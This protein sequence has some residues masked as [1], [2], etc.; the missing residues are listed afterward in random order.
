M[1]LTQA[2]LFVAIGGMGMLNPHP[3]GAIAF[4]ASL[5]AFLRPARTS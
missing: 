1:M 2:S 4:M 3:G 5:V